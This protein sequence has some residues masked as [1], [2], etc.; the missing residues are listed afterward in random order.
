MRILIRVAGF[1][2]LAIGIV[3]FVLP[4]ASLMII[5]GLALLATEFAWARSWFQK[6][7]R[8]ASGPR[9]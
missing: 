4:G 9:S 8:I 3:F 7:G 1:S 5:T 6:A 2:L